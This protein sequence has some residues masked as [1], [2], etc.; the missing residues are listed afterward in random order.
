MQ[1]RTRRRLIALL[2]VAGS[3]GLGACSPRPDCGT[4][5]VRPGDRARVVAGAPSH[6]IG[7]RFFGFN[8]E[9]T[10][11]E[12]SFWD[13]T[14]RRVDPALVAAL[15]PFA[16]AVYRFPGGTTANHFD[17]ALALGPPASRK[18][19]RIVDWTTLDRID[20]GLAE[21]AAFVRA[22]GGHGWYVLNLYG[23][24]DA[25]RPIETLA[26]QAQQAVRAFADA[27]L[28]P[29]RYE[30]GNELDRGTVRWPSA[31]YVDRARAVA[32]AV[33]A[34]DPDARFTGMLSDYDAQADRGITASQFNRAVLGGLDDT[35]IDGWAQHLYYDGPPEGP[36]LPNRLGHLCRT[37]RDIEQAGAAGGAEVWV[38]EHA[39]WPQADGGRPWKS[40]WRRSA[41][42]DAALATAD[43]VIALSQSPAVRGSM[44]HALHATG[45]PW[46]LLHADARRASDAPAEDAARALRPSA[47]FEAY[48]MLRQTLLPQV[49]SST[50]TSPKRSSY[51]GGYDV[52]AS[53]L[54]D[55][56]GTRYAVWAVNRDA[57]EQSLQVQAAALANR[58]VTV[59]ATVLAS[60]DGEASNHERQRVV[61]ESRPA[62]QLDFDADGA[63]LI[64]L[65]ARSI[66]VATLALE[67]GRAGRTAR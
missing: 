59:H 45:G 31:T 9:L 3:P 5:D 52:R 35:A 67:P 44:L 58:R 53:I 43:F 28:A 62:A 61:P 16:G 37:V 14:R 15:A 2:L 36:P 64:A 48:R 19:A 60:A 10:E 12:L 41:D 57:K 32:K 33:R 7:E 56:G 27:G 23:S 24:I 30:L 46:P 63:A 8:L 49:L 22:V 4:L 20:F 26:A 21:Y 6:R 11:F 65:P 38:T 29:L 25:E 13:R 40:S 42:F 54:R 39:R 50:T 1:S 66:V 55:D 17:P 47:V 34:V 51:P 18:S